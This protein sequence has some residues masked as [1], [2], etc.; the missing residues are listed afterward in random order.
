[1]KKIN[2]LL[3]KIGGVLLAAIVLTAQMPVAALAEEPAAVE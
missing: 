2:E 3:R 1:M